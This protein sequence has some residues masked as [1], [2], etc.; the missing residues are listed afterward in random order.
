MNFLKL[1]SIY[2]I[3]SLDGESAV[4][5]PNIL[6]MSFSVAFQSLP[7]DAVMNLRVES[8]GILEHGV[9]CL[10]TSFTRD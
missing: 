5:F 8:K 2:D 1:W 4:I 7:L 10:A 3:D 9:E 6:E